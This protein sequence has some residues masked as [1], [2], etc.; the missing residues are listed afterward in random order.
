MPQN[1]ADMLRVI[2]DDN[3]NIVSAMLHDLIT[4]HQMGDG[5]KARQAQLRYEQA[6]EGVPVF[7]KQFADYEKA[8]EKIP[9]DFFSDIIDLKT[10]YM[11]GE[12]VI[13]VD[14]RKAPT[15]SER[16]DDD[17]FLQD[18]VQRESLTDAN[19]ELVKTA[20]IA[21]RG[22]RMLYVSAA[23]GR[24]HVMNSD[25]WETMVFA[26]A[27]IEEPAIAIRY[28]PIDLVTYDAGGGATS[29][30]KR[31]LLEW[32]DREFITYYR[33]NE[34][35]IFE[36]DTSQPEAGPFRGTGR[37]PHL[38]EGVPVI[39]FMNNKEGKGEAEKVLEL[40]DGYDNIMSDAVNEVEQLRM[41]YMWAK[42]AGMHLDAEFEKRLEQ[43][44]VWPL[45]ETGSIGFAEKGFAAG[46]FVI[47]LMDEIRRNIYSFA[48]SIDLS[49]DRGGNMRVIG[50]QIALLR[51]E[52]S[53][54]VTERKFKRSYVSQY[55]L[56][57]RFWGR[58]QGI[59]IDSYALKFKFTRKFPKDIDQEIDTLVKAM[60][61]LPPEDAYALMSWIDNP[62]EMAEKWEKVKPGIL[63]S[64]SNSFGDEE[65]AQ[66]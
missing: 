63:K 10:G 17:T 57:S 42:G 12:I 1:T 40:I 58:Y 48:K 62:K 31:W 55:N 16:A 11:G 45:P 25:P 65:N 66:A 23:D 61:V 18:F 13:E 38:F 30:K 27:G 21:G 35:G 50:W 29:R 34:S 46:E 6:R 41:A 9:N 52:M 7:S 37:Q 26:D 5:R 54:Q 15:E 28:Y 36:I 24:A 8:H 51:L 32:Y 19:S 60:D 44:G 43:T 20:A 49:Q 33:E 14:Q 47:S 4:M 53:A 59:Q 56:L 64:L 22:Y 3:E 39:E 2:R